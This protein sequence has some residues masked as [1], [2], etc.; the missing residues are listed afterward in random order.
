M[1]GSSQ[2]RARQLAGRNRRER[3]SSISSCTSSRSISSSSQA[4][5]QSP[6]SILEPKVPSV[7]EEHPSCEHDGDGIVPLAFAEVDSG[8]QDENSTPPFLALQ[9]ASG[10]LGP[11]AEQQRL[12]TEHLSQV[13]YNSLASSAPANPPQSQ[14]SAARHTRYGS[15]GSGPMPHALR[16]TASEYQLR[17][18]TVVS[19]RGGS[20]GHDGVLARPAPT[21]ADKMDREILVDDREIAAL[22]EHR[23]R[24]RLDPAYRDLWN[25]EKDNKCYF[26]GFL[27]LSGLPARHLWDEPIT[28]GRWYDVL[29]LQLGN[30]LYR[31]C[32]LFEPRGDHT[33]RDSLL[34]P[35]GRITRVA[36]FHCLS[37]EYKTL[38]RNVIV[39]RLNELAKTPRPPRYP[40]TKPPIVMTL[41]IQTFEQ[42]VHTLTLVDSTPPR[43]PRFHI[44]IFSHLHTYSMLISAL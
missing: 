42:F 38:F 13:L 7:I 20:G 21:I 27:R 33:V 34:D 24:L 18:Q 36:F 4:P 29:A 31:F 40:G 10:L 3:I 6:T 23:T 11:Q 43:Y 12:Q 37:L 1:F 28:S 39:E 9:F 44:A 35:T 8:Q 25:A 16:G 14:F 26:G 15:L 5:Q 41:L 2:D 19:M 32:M 22:E 17:P 30:E